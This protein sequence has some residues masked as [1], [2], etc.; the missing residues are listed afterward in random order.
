MFENH[1]TGDGD[2]LFSTFLDTCGDRIEDVESGSHVLLASELYFK[3]YFKHVHPEWCFLDRNILQGWFRAWK[4]DKI[5]RDRYR[6]FFLRLVCATGALFCSSGDDNCTHLLRSKRLYQQATQID[7]PYAFSLNSIICTQ[8]SLLIITHFLHSPWLDSHDETLVA[9]TAYCEKVLGEAEAWKN[10]SLANMKSALGGYDPEL[11]TS[12]DL[13]RI[14][15]TT[16]YTIN[17]IVSTT[18]NRYRATATD[19]LVPLWVCCYSHHFLYAFTDCK[20]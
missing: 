9:A 17:E 7:A 2:Y 15:F 10:T 3:L 20:L 1:A 19:S 11:S 4:R 5:L 12:E 14:V 8:A 6:A 13:K 16:C 18:W